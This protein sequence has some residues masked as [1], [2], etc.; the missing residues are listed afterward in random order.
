MPCVT[1]HYTNPKNVFTPKLLNPSPIGEVACHG[2]EWHSGPCPTLTLPW[3]DLESNG[4][5]ELPHE[6]DLTTW[7]NQANHTIMPKSQLYTQKC[8]RQISKCSMHVSNRKVI[9][10]GDIDQ[11][12]M[13]KNIPSLAP[14]P[15]R[16]CTWHASQVSS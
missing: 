8:I 11:R 6:D 9:Y 5:G 15:L 10:K 3:L 2:L 1:S 16:L 4:L 12:S 14:K 7:Q 13:P